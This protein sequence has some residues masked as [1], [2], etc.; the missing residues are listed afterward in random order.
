MWLESPQD[1]GT[2]TGSRMTK[3]VTATVQ[4][5]SPE[6]LACDKVGFET[7]IW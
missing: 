6:L 5:A 4:W 2:A 1:L 7:D 3:D